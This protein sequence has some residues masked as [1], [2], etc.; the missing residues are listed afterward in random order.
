M[1]LC[2]CVLYIWNGTFDLIGKYHSFQNFVRPI[3]K[4][5]FG[6]FSTNSN[7][8][9]RMHIFIPMY[10]VRYVKNA[11]PKAKITNKIYRR[12]GEKNREIKKMEINSEKMQAT[13]II[14][15]VNSV[16]CSN[17][18]LY[19]FQKFNIQI[20]LEALRNKCTQFSQN[21]NKNSDF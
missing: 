19:L 2:L 13:K 15:D 17:I 3:V 16:V 21:K 20:H 18:T 7:D 8:S 6:Y 9:M 4:S 12:T 5:D 10:T 14:N 1:F 11:E